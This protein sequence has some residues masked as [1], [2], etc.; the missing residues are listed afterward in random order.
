M[1]LTS[2]IAISALIAT[3]SFASEKGGEKLAARKI[4]SAESAAP[5]AMTCKTETRTAIDT[6]ARGAFKSASVHTVHAC[7]T[8]ETKEVTQGAGKL[9]TRKVVHTCAQANVCCPSK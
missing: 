2:L 6:S 5:S 8:C 4:I 9:A 7:P 1:K 3:A